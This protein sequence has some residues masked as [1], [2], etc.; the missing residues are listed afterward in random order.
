VPGHRAR[1]SPSTTRA[2]FVVL[3]GQTDAGKDWIEEH[4]QEGDYNPFGRGARLV[5]PRYIG[6]SWPGAV[7][8]GLVVQ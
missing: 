4:C 2:R 1:P 5:E 7:D 6:L 8:D 3:C